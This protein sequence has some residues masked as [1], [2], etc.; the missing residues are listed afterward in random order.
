MNRLVAENFR[1][2]VVAVRVEAD[3]LVLSGVAG[4]LHADG[5]IAP[6]R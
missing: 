1:R 5:D 4:R 6:F 3:E 2:D